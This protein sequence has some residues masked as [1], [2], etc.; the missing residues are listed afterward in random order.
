MEHGKRA[1]LGFTTQHHANAI[2]QRH[3]LHDLA[4]TLRCANDT[5]K[6]WQMPARFN[7]L[8]VFINQATPQPPAHPG[9]VI[10]VEADVLFLGVLDG[11][12]AEL[13]KEF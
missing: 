12:R 10:W 2:T 4:L 6:L 8:L 1:F 13:G 11:H 3:Q 5:F 9:N 7:I